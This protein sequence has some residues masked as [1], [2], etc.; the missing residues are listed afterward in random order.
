M[1]RKVGFA[2]QTRAPCSVA[3]AQCRIAQRKSA[4]SAW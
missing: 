1:L 4:K 2:L 3:K